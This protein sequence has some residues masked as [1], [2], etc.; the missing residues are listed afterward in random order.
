MS[1][2]QLSPESDK[3]AANPIKIGL[4][5][6][7]AAVGVIFAIVMVAQFA[8]G[9]YAGR[10][11][12]DDPALSP[13]AIAKRLKPVGELVIDPNAPGLSKSTD[14]APP[15][16][17][18]PSSASDAAPKA[19]GVQAAEQQAASPTQGSAGATAA[20]NQAAVATP[21]AKPAAAVPISAEAQAATPAKTEKSAAASAGNAKTE[22]SAAASAG[23]TGKG[24]ATYEAVCF[25]CHAAGVANAPKFADKAAW[26]PRIATGM[27]TLYHSVLNGKGAM[28]AKGGNA[29]LGEADVKAAVDYM[30]SQAK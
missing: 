13:E 30:V 27:D 29:A 21:E 14:A 10:A 23:S 25:V 8:I 28:P 20:S 2:P 12:K 15:A 1:A 7:A 17:T 24:K 22:K 5:I 16:S 4:T 6:A 11:L 19:D 26:A 9:S 18:P 3:Q